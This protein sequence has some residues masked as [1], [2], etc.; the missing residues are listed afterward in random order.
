MRLQK[1]FQAITL[2]VLIV[3]VGGVALGDG[4]QDKKK[5]DKKTDSKSSDQKKTDLSHAKEVVDKVR[6]SD[7]PEVHS[8]TETAKDRAD[9]EN[10]KEQEREKKRAQ[11]I[12]KKKAKEPPSLHT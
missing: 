12:N 3:S 7:D 10:K 5:D 8:S 4:Q 1:Y 6:K 2:G 9:K 11:E